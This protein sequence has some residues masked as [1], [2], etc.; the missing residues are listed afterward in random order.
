M[1]PLRIYIAGPY[2]A[3]SEEERKRNVDVAVDAGLRLLKKGHFPFIPHLTH[4]V[5][6][7]AIET[8]SQ[9][10]WE[11]YINWDLGWLEASDALLLLGRSRGAD[12]ECGRAKELGKVI[13][14]SIEEI[15]Q[16]SA[17]S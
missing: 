8:G 5:D 2:S 10:E 13:F 3:P 9:L 7:R 15:P 17:E 4:F 6:L 14:N 1:R 11:D 12:I 16:A